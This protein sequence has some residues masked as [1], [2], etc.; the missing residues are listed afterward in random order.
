MQNFLLAARAP[1]LGAC[2]TSWASYGGERL[3]GEAIGIP[4]DW[5]IAGHV[6]IGWPKGKHGPP[7]R[8]PL[9][10]FVDL[11]RWGGPADDLLATL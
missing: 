4:E 9:A 5:M 7:R 2:M 8:R 1:G 11:D 10:E 6:V 3:L